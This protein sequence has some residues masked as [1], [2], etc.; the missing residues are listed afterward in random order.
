MSDEVKAIQSGLRNDAPSANPKDAM[1]RAKASL[2]LIPPPALFEM[3]KAM[4]FGADKYGAY[5]WR[6]SRVRQMVYL[7]AALRHIEQL[8]DGEDLDDE[9]RAAHEAHVMAGMAIIIDAR[10]YNMLIDDRP[11]TP[12]PQGDSHGR[13]C[14]DA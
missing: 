8:I 11:V 5:N 4:R 6:R 14:D 3:A 10:K 2:A 13:R 1:G 7:E 12:A 9:S